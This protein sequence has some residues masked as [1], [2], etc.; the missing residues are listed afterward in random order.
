MFSKT[1]FEDKH[2]FSGGRTENLG[3][4]SHGRIGSTDDLDGLSTD[5]PN[6]HDGRVLIETESGGDGDDQVFMWMMNVDDENRVT[7]PNRQR[8]ENTG[9]STPLPPFV[10]PGVNSHLICIP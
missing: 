5:R 6:R 7:G 9:L 1:K 3:G 4:P 10:P 8:I 2:N